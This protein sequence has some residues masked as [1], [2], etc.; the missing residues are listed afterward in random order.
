MFTSSYTAESNCQK[1]NRF[2]VEQ[3]SQLETPIIDERPNCVS[4]GPYRVVT[5][6]KIYETWQGRTRLGEFHRRSWGVGYVLSLYRGDRRISASLLDANKQYIKLDEEKYIYNYHI[7]KCLQRNDRD[8][9]IL[10]KN[11]LSRVESEMVGL[12]LKVNTI[13]KNIHIG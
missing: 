13:L 4:V 2:F 1:I 3:I 5:N 6:S 7:N 12:D 8:K 10:L 11:R 9:E